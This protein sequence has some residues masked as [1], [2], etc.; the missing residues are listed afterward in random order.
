MPVRAEA[1]RVPEADIVDW[2]RRIHA[3]PEL[4]FQEVETSGFVAETLSRFPGVEVSRPTATSVLGVLHGARPGATVALRADMDALPIDEET[5][6]AFS[7]RKPGVMHACGHDAHTAMLLGAAAALADMRARIAGTVKFVFQHAE[8]QPPGGARELVRAG[9]VDDVDAIFG[10]HVANQER[11]TIRVAKGPAS[12]SADQLLLTI[13][14]R[15]SHGSMPQ[16]GIDPVLVGA[17]I[18]VALNTIVSRAV[19]PAHM[20]VVNVGAFRA[21]QAPNVIPE[22]AQLGVSVRTTSPEDRELVRR[23]VEEVVDGVCAAYGAAGEAEW[24]EGYAIIQNDDGLAEVALGAAARALGADRVAYG[25]RSPASEDFSAYTERVP[26]CFLTLGGGTAAD[27]RPYQNHHP[28]F[29]IDER[30]LADGARTEVQIVL[31]MLGA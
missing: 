2:R 6:L 21:G 5:G 23:R 24:M 30:V 31:D 1:I 29:D 26:G 25:T 18:V 4:S 10:L 8:E 27:G 17:Q 22:T 15:G 3:N 13:R 19:D 9:V 7:S 11:G 14:G 12:T 16:Q 28:K 20:A